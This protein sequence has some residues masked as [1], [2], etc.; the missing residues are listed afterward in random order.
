PP[1]HGGYVLGYQRSILADRVHDLLSAIA[2]ARGM[3]GV[4]RVHL[5]ASGEQG[6]AGLLARALAGAEVERAAIDLG[7][8]DF[9]RVTGD[10]DPMLLPG[11]LKYG[12]IYAFVPL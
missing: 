7:Q 2:M 4:R 8:F 5:L 11:A 6:P 1:Y 10:T 3:E 9:D 12:G